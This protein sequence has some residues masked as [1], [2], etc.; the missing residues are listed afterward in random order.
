MSTHTL[1]IDFGTGQ[2][3][4]TLSFRCTAPAGELCHALY[5]CSCEEWTDEGVV[6]GKP[7]HLDMDDVT[8]FGYWRNDECRLEDWFDG[9]DEVV[10][11]SVT[12]PVRPTWDGGYYGFDITPA[13]AVTS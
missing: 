9:S 6:H 2:D 10:R 13:E 5:E 3:T 4:A 11:G 8:H 7:F 12:V 1:T